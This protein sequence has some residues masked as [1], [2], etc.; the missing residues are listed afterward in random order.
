MFPSQLGEPPFEPQGSATFSLGEGQTLA[1]CG[2]FCRENGELT[3][4]GT[5]R[6]LIL[7]KRDNYLENCI[8]VTINQVANDDVR[9][10]RLSRW[11]LKSF[12]EKNEHEGQRVN[13]EGARDVL[14]TRRKHPLPLEMG[15]TTSFVDQE[16]KVRLANLSRDMH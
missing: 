1:E 13:T 3:C 11:R 15:V 12:L 5:A 8:V 10:Q 2:L 16:R 14:I 6:E 7:M 9:R 4:E